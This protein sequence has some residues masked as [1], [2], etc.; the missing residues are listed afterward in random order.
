[1][2]VGKLVYV[3]NKMIP[4]DQSNLYNTSMRDG[5]YFIAPVLS[6]IKESNACSMHLRLHVQQT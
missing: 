1:M 5:S 2:Y 3:Y 4:N 6:E